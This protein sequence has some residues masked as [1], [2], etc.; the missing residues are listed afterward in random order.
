MQTSCR[1]F[2]LLNEA[3]LRQNKIKSSV[4]TLAVTFGSVEEYIMNLTE[5]TRFNLFYQ[6]YLNE[7]TLQGKSEKTIDCYSRCLRQTATF[8]DIYPD[9]LTIE[10]L[11]A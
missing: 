1:L 11:K 6:S 10:D 4:L 2:F 3:T 9:Q 8:F 5:Q 7:L